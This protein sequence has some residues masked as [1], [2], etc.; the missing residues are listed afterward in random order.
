[1]R[2]IFWRNN[3]LISA[4]ERA[5]F[6]DGST[7]VSDG[8]CLAR[9][10]RNLKEIFNVEKN[11]AVYPKTARV[12]GLRAESAELH[13]TTL[14]NQDLVKV[15]STSAITAIIM[16]MSNPLTSAPGRDPYPILRPWFSWAETSPVRRVHRRASRSPGVKGGTWTRGKRCGSTPVAVAVL[17]RILPALRQ[18]KTGALHA[19]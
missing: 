5:D 14:S 17:S 7:R 2:K 10:E 19:P 3:V 16:K 8:K 12:Y 1:M 13:G 6:T 18:R 9:F 15:I 4:E 11:T